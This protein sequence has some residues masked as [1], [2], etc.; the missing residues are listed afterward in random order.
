M[1]ARITAASSTICTHRNVARALSIG[2]F[3]GPT[4]RRA[5]GRRARDEDSGGTGAQHRPVGSSQG[6][7][8]RLGGVSGWWS[9]RVLAGQLQVIPAR[10]TTKGAKSEIGHPR[11]RLTL[12]CRHQNRHRAVGD[13]R[14]RRPCRCSAR[15]HRMSRRTRNAIACQSARETT[16]PTGTR[17]RYD[18]SAWKT[19]PTTSPD[20]RFG[21]STGVLRFGARVDGGRSRRLSGPRLGR[22]GTIGSES[23]WLDGR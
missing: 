13:L 7:G 2:G 20:R 1:V 5:V 21:G 15:R 17:R 14:G 4:H 12:T 23:W 11:R 22:D 8:L 6:R 19:L 10:V 3:V 16:K 9:S 18:R